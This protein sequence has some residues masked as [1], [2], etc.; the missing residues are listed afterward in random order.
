MPEY[1]ILYSRKGKENPLNQRGSDRMKTYTVK[2]INRLWYVM[3]VNEEGKKLAFASFTT[4]TVAMKAKATYE[5]G[6]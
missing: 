5:K 1:D 4:K 6:K 3:E 2:K